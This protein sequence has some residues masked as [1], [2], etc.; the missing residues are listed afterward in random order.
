M[1][2]GSLYAGE[3]PKMR[4]CRMFTS[5]RPHYNRLRVCPFLWNSPVSLHDVNQP[6]KGELN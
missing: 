6:A 3:L 4:L 2:A 1:G 5:N